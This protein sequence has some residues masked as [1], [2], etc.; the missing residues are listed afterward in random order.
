MVS[1]RIYQLRRAILLAA[2]EYSPGPVRLDDIVNHPSVKNL[3]P[4]REE[5]VEQWNELA[6]RDYLKDFP[7]SNGEYREITPKGRNQLGQE[8]ER[9]VFIWGRFGRIPEE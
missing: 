5:L 4:A 8:G 2:K 9:R 7:G 1:D 3:I 6:A